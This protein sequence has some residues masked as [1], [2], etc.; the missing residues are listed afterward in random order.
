MFFSPV[1]FGWGVERKVTEREDT[2]FF[3]ELPNGT[4]VKSLR[5]VWFSP[6]YVIRQSFYLRSFFLCFDLHIETIYGVGL[7][8][9]R[10]IGWLEAWK[11]LRRTAKLFISNSDALLLTVPFRCL[12][13]LA[14]NEMDIC[15]HSFCYLSNSRRN[16]K[17]LLTQ[18]WHLLDSSSLFSS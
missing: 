7:K 13:Q 8:L 12:C 2:C 10:E 17:K 6:W 5:T 18:M 11:V 15:L 4:V 14:G 9:V 16:W 1:I 3:M